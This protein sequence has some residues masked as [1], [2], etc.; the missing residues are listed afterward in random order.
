MNSIELEQ[1]KNDLAVKV[2]IL[3]MKINNG[4]ITDDTALEIVNSYKEY[5]KNGTTIEELKLLYE[6]VQLALS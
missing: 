1:L 6:D 2:G 5:E 4:D 3:E